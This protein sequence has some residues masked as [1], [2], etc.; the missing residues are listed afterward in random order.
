[1]T[2]AEPDSYHLTEYADIWQFAR[3][4]QGIAGLPHLSRHALE[5][6]LS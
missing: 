5:E 6:P 4:A 3:H 1:M 2:H